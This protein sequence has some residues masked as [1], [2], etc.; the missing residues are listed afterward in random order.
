M[1]AL[2]KLRKYFFTI[3]VDARDK[4]ALQNIDT[5]D[6]FYD[7]FETENACKPDQPWRHEKMNPIATNLNE[8]SRLW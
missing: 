6:T 4:N 3:F 8:T 5:R 2:V 1:I 7:T